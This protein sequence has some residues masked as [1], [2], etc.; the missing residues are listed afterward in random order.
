MTDASN[1]WKV[2]YKISCEIEGLN[3]LENKSAQTSYLFDHPSVAKRKGI[4]K[5]YYSSI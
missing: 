3:Y 5:H 1:F 4:N 2:S